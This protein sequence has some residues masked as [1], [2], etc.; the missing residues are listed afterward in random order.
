[1]SFLAVR[2]STLG[3]ARVRGFNTPLHGA[4]LVDTSHGVTMVPAYSSDSDIVAA[5][6]AQAAAGGEG[7]ILAR[8]TPDTQDGKEATSLGIQGG[9]AWCPTNNKFYHGSNLSGAIAIKAGPIADT[10]EPVPGATAGAGR[11]AIWHASAGEIWVAYD[12]TGGNAWARIDPSDDSVT[13]V[14]GQ[15]P[16]DFTYRGGNIYFTS[17]TAVYKVTA[18]GTVTAIFT[19]A[20]AEAIAGG[21]LANFAMRGIE[22][23]DSLGVIIFGMTHTAG[24][25]NFWWQIDGSDNVSVKESGGATH[26]WY[27]SDFDK[28]IMQAIS[29]TPAPLL[30]VDPANFSSFVVLTGNQMV[31]AKGCYCGS[32]AKIALPTLASSV[33]S[34]RFFGAGEL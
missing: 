23:I 4:L 20:D 27:S 2:Q 11:R 22:Y 10:F 33:Y 9:A 32:I 28:I 6:F 13:M 26:V 1:M 12:G 34:V 24:T 25:Y 7:A 18:A 29:G 8:R 31:A 17:A 16:V 21:P 30:S 19:Q 5:G 14:S 15:T 3:A